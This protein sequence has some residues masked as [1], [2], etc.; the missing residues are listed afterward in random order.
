LHD[1]EDALAY[2]QNPDDTIEVKLHQLAE[3]SS[4]IN[5]ST[6][7]VV[8]PITYNPIEA[9]SILGECGINLGDN[10]LWHTSSIVI[11]LPKPD[12]LHTM[13]LRMLKHLLGWLQQLMKMFKQLS[14][15]NMLWLSVLAY[16]TMM[17]PKKSYEEVSQWTGNELR[18]MSRYLLAVITNTLHVLNASE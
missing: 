6:L 15:Y 5:S 10:I 13:Q 16:L 7:P 12:L 14:K 17:K 2:L 3:S 9:A 18:T 11:D 8:K 1:A 4:D